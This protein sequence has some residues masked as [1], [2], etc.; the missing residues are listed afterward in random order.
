MRLHA[1]ECVYIESAAL[2]VNL[3]R[4]S[5]EATFHRTSGPEGMAHLTPRILRIRAVKRGSVLTSY[6][7]GCQLRHLDVDYALLAGRGLYM[8]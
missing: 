8:V 3:S 6:K 2:H 7:A 5:D 1:L 4:L